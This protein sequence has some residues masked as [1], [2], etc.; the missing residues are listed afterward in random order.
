[1]R[2]AIVEDLPGTTRD[3]LYGETDWLAVPFTIIDT[4]G[5][6]D[7]DEFDRLAPREISVRTRNQA[8]LAIQEADRMGHL[9]VGTEHL[10]LGLVGERESAAA[11]LLSEL[12]ARPE[13]IQSKVL[14]LLKGGRP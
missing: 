9:F 1:M 13:R 10:L 8:E 7:E 2:T 6:Q 11:R 3:R 12:G 4:G 14:R 5:L